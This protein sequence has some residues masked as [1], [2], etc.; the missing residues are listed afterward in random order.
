MGIECEIFIERANRGIFR[1]RQPVV[2]KVKYFISKPT[3]FRTIDISFLG[4]ATCQWS[5]P[6]PDKIPRE[7]YNEEE[8]VNDSRNLFKAQHGQEVFLSGTFEYPFEFLLP[9]NIPS[10]TKYYKGGIIEYKVIVLF[11][12]AKSIRTIKEYNRSIPV[13]GYV[14][15]CSREPLIFSLQKTLSSL[16]AIS[17]IDIKGEIEKTFL[18][19]GDK[20][21]LK[22]TINNNTDV[23]ITINT[24]LIENYIYVSEDETTNVV[25]MPLENTQSSITIVEKS[26]SVITC[27]VPTLPTLYSIQ[28]SKI[29]SREYKVRV[30]AKLPNPKDNVDVEVPVVIGERKK[31]VGAAAAIDNEINSTFSITPEIDVGNLIEL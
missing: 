25:S 14:C 20:I 27:I 2:G 28:N 13:Y 9:D 11:V 18:T 3:M 7:Y 12:K 26:F 4:K 6:G 29:L 23:L 31:E 15:P 24:K 8:Y 16:T 5:T 21:K 17:N 30:T 22:L 1:P 19:P 10:S